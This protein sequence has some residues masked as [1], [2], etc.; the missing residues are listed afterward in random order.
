[1]FNMFGGI[2]TKEDL[3]K[4][5]KM[6]LVSEKDKGLYNKYIVK[7]VSG[8]EL[9]PCIVME[10]KDPIARKAIYTWA[11]EMLNEGYKNVFIDTMRALKAHQNEK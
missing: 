8:K 5:D 11:R 3:E 7:K 10:F 2:P 1:M 9:G 4:M 6:D